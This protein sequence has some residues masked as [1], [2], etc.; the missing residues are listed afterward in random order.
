MTSLRYFNVSRTVY[1]LYPVLLREQALVLQKVLQGT[2]RWSAA[3]KLELFKWGINRIR[4][5]MV[6]G[7]R[8]DRPFRNVN[9]MSRET[10]II[11]VDFINLGQNFFLTQH[12][13]GWQALNPYD[14]II[15]KLPL[16]LRKWAFSIFWHS[17]IQR[18]SCNIWNYVG[19]I[20]K[21]SYWITE[22]VNTVLTFEETL[23]FQ[24]GVTLPFTRIIFE[25]THEHIPE[26]SFLLH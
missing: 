9:K 10:N 6:S 16:R 26:S 21:K 22:A 18:K 15:R 4:K 1:P 7:K 3:L 11:F 19:L 14:S 2:T 8:S 23:S 12:N 17:F 24:K 5:L 13:S 25:V 20:L